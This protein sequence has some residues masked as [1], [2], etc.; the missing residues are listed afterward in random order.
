[1]RIHSNV[2]SWNQIMDAVTGM[3]NVYVTVSVRGSRSHAAAFET[4]MEGNGHRGNSG[5][6]GARDMS[7]PLAATWDEWGVFLGRL[8]VIDP[9]MIVGTPKN[10]IYASAEHFNW[11]TGNRFMP[12][13]SDP[14]LTVRLP[15]DTHKRHA[16]NYSEIVATGR[17]SVST[18]KGSKGKPCSAI[19]RFVAYGYSFSDL[20]TQEV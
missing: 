4:S 2:L 7:Q 13:M 1:M 12:A 19:R 15:I 14:T 9:E 5:Q 3:P 20:Q 6:Y 10:P 18:C 17:Y 11:S 16:W 8:Y